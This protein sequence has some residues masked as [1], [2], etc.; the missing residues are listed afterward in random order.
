MTIHKIH[1]VFLSGEPGD[2]VA[3]RDCWINI[4]LPEGVLEIEQET[5]LHKIVSH[6]AIDIRQN[7]LHFIDASRWKADPESKYKAVLPD[8]VGMID[9]RLLED[10]CSELAIRIFRLPEISP[11]Y[12]GGFFDRPSASTDKEENESITLNNDHALL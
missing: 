2:H 9:I 8:K 7:P 6:Y 3:L 11:L 5:L 12:K 1:F 10:S 4:E